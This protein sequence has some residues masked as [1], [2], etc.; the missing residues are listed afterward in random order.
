MTFASPYCKIDGCSRW[1][2]NKVNGLCATHE[3]ESKS[4]DRAKEKAAM[5]RT[6]FIA[7][8]GDTE[9]FKCSSGRR[10]SQKEINSKRASTYDLMDTRLKGATKVCAATGVNEYDTIIDHD[11]TIAQARCKELGKTELIWDEKNIEYSSRQAHR[12]WESY[13]DGKFIAHANFQKRMQFVKAHDPEAWER[14][15]AVAAQMTIPKQTI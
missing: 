1:A 4:I 2:V 12:E 5:A 8:V 6:P 15:M 10:V 3:R 13:G 11:H 7:K 14:R 9:K